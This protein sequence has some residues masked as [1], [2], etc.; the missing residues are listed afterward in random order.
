[1]DWRMS[2][3]A[4]VLLAGLGAGSAVAADYGEGNARVRLVR[5][6]EKAGTG[7]TFLLGVEFDIRPG[8]HIYWRNPGGA[9]LATDIQ[10]RLPP[11]AAAGEL[12]WPLPVGFTQSGEIPGY[13]YEESVVLAAEF[14]SDD[15]LEGDQAVGASVSWL[16]CRD[17]CVLGS[18]ELQSPLAALP[19]D[20][21]FV[22]WPDI[23]PQP[24]D[25]ENPAFTVTA[26]GG[27]AEGTLG[28]WL[29]WRQAPRAVEWFPAP[30]E[31]LEVTG[32]TIQTRGGLTRIDSFVRRMQGSS[33]TSSTLES[34]VVMT[35]DDGVRRGWNLA[36]DVGKK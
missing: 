13:G 25:E 10:W 15:G 7:T 19:I 23:L 5:S 34:V 14:R 2:V 33:G 18:A 24:F 8:W 9:G 29:Q 26:R 16:A 12:Q 30:P 22:K 31:G 27:L 20:D 35:D 32:V 6:A 1:M 11:G 3:P 21:A 17:V 28:L 4:V 36:V